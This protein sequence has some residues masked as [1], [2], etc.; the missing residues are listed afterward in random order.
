MLLSIRFR[1]L[2]KKKDKTER[3]EK[4]RKEKKGKEKKRKEKKTN[5][6]KHTFL[7]YIYIAI[8]IERRNFCLR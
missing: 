4:K 6:Q 3:K 8:K 2:S 5:K 1:T 7:V